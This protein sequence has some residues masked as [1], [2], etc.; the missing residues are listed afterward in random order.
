MNKETFMG[1]VTN[2][3]YERGYGFI[4]DE[5]NED[6]FFHADDVRDIPFRELRPQTVVTFDPIEHPYRRPGSGRR[7]VNIQK[8]KT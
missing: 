8:A 4:R 5:N 6:R 3:L 2:I 7:A 1:V